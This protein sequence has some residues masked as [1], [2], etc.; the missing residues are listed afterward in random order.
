MV[1]NTIGKN[2]YTNYAFPV[3]VTTDLNSLMVEEAQEY[4]KILH[5]KS[6]ICRFNLNG[7]EYV[8]IGAHILHLNDQDRISFIDVTN[9]TIRIVLFQPKIVNAIFDF[10]IIN[11]SPS[12]LTGAANQDLFYLEQFRHDT[13]EDKKILPLMMID[14]TILEN[15]IDCLN[16]L[17]ANQ[18]TRSWPCLSRSYLYEILFALVRQGGLKDYGSSLENYSNHSKLAIDIIYYLQNNYNTKIS[19]DSLVKEFNTNRTTLH[20]DFK[21]HTGLSINQYLVQIRMNMAAKLLRDT[22]LTLSE[23]CERI[24]F[25]DTIYFSK[26]FKKALNQTPSEYRNIYR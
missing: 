23:I 26:V 14:S 10:S 20:K 8:L 16:N 24:G 9:L 3:L 4:C 11:D 5:I 18:D 19:I 6:G 13:A 22:S 7:K 25:S 1:L 17:L 2:Y 15:K 21:K 12:K